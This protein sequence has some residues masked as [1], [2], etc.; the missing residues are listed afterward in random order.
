MIGCILGGAAAAWVA[1]TIANAFTEGAQARRDNCDHSLYN[2]HCHKCG[3]TEEPYE[4]P[5]NT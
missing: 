2:G 1:K 4:D 3:Y 5:Y